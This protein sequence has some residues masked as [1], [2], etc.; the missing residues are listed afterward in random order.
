[1]STREVGAI[2]PLHVLCAALVASSKDFLS[3][4][5]RICIRVTEEWKPERLRYNL[6]MN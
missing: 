1:M 5:I 6:D 4:T 2:C 3:A